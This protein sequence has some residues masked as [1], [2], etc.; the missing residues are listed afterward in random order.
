[1]KLIIRQ[2]LAS[3]NERQELDAVL[4]DIL[5]ELGLNVYSRPGRG[6][7]QDGVDVAAVGKIDSETE[8]VYLFSIKAGDLGRTDWD[9]NSAQALR[10]SLNEIIDAYIPTRLPT[11][12]KDKKI[13]ICLCFGGEI[14]E[15]VRQQVTGYVDKHTTDRISF[16]EWNG[17]KLADLIQSSF[18]KE[19]LLPDNARGQLRKALALIDEPEASH[20]HFSTLVRGIASSSMPKARD[21]IRAIR[22]IGIC[23]WIH[24]SWSRDAGNLESAYLS[25]ECALLLGW[26]LTKP[27]ASKKTKTAKAILDAYQSIV[28]AYQ[29]VSFGFLESKVFP[30]VNKRH[31]LSVAVH[32]SCDTDVNLRMFDM[33]GRIALAGIWTYSAIDRVPD[34]KPEV[35]QKII[36][37]IEECS[38]NI[39]LLINNNPPLFLPLKDD[40][41]IDISLAILLLLMQGKSEK[42][43]LS[44]LHEIMDRA[45]FSLMVLGK[46]PCNL[47]T[48]TELIEHPRKE[49][50][51]LESS[52]AG[53]VLYPMISLFACICRDQNLYDK[54]NSVQSE[55]LS[56]CNF[57]LWFP[58]A[59]T[60]DHLYSN[61]EI[62]GAA[63]SNLSTMQSIKAFAEQVF[64]ECD[65]SKQFH[66][67][68]AAQYGI[69]PIIL[70]ACRHYRL[71]IPV[72]LFRDLQVS[73]SE[74]DE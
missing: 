74:G 8:K 30:Y 25:S 64:G 22:Q 71:P 32:A 45:K 4:P 51:Y 6:T 69:W 41:A 37:S 2:Y 58:D 19:E 5:S 10:P 61:S 29:S 60:E 68:S 38:E 44:W 33:L 7:R 70:V 39:K 27:H 59:I 53:S 26:E 15:Q 63:L 18:L 36:E 1:L 13:V 43:I 52:T 17:D 12:H 46:F 54:V 47:Q 16:E 57:Q 14:K 35:K 65:Q 24:Y 11:E 48:Y 9:G 56:H 28:H 73:G 49:Q 50:D 3:L 42:F 66:E 20:N 23:L 62:H 55:Y 21:K 72:H 40:Q 67:L 31:A 34:N